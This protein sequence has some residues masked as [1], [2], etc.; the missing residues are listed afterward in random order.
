MT[1]FHS[2]K[3]EANKA[4]I[5][6]FIGISSISH[7]NFE[8]VA[9]WVLNNA[10]YVGSGNMAGRKQYVEKV[11]GKWFVLITASFNKVGVSLYGCSNN[12]LPM[13]QAD[14]ARMAASR[15]LKPTYR[16]P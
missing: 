11:K 3:Y 1:A 16:A 4:K 5:A 8:L 6:K 2:N 9:K 10:T 13:S 14:V 12:G 15:G 7:A